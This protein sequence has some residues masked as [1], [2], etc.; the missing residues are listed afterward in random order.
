MGMAASSLRFA[1]LTARKNQVEFE[2][3]QINQQRLTLSQKSTALFNDML[4]KQVPTAPDPSAFTR[5]VYKFN[6]GFGESSILNLA[7]KA[8][9]AYNY[10]V[11]YKR[12]KTTKTLSRSSF[13][14]VGFT[15]TLGVTTSDKTKASYYARTA[16]VNGVSR[17]L[18]LVGGDSAAAK[19]QTYRDKL[20]TYNNMK[21]IEEQIRS[22]NNKNGSDVCESS[23]QQNIKSA[24]GLTT[25]N[26]NGIAQKLFGN[27]GKSGLCVTGVFPDVLA[28]NTSGINDE[29][30]KAAEAMVKVL[31]GTAANLDTNIT[32]QNLSNA[33]NAL[34]SL[35][36]SSEQL[37][38]T[39][40]KDKLFTDNTLKN[41]YDFTSAGA[42]NPDSKDLSSFQNL[43]E[44]E[45]KELINLLTAYAN[46]D[47]GTI[48]S[49]D[50]KYQV[51][52]TNY[53][54]YTNYENYGQAANSLYNLATGQAADNT[55]TNDQMVEM[56]NELLKEVGEGS[57]SSGDYKTKK[58]DPAF[59]Q[60]Q[61]ATATA[62]IVNIAAGQI[63]YEYQDDDGQKCYMYVSNE[64]VLDDTSSTYAE[65][66]SVYEN[67]L[68]Y[69]EGEMETESQDANVI[70]SDEGQ[71]SKITFAD[72]TVVTPEVVTEMD[73]DAYN[74]AMVEYEYKKDVYD[75][76]MN[77]C[78]AKVKIIQAQDQK[79]EVRLKQLDTEQKALST[80]IEALKSI[81]DKAI[82]SSFKTFS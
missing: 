52:D 48:S 63:L 30:A 27:T 21:T 56:L 79:L 75:K 9:G 76:E 61:S 55:V 58:V 41:E 82:E 31:N 28:L 38:S 5:I 14:N 26:R 70:M 7:R 45:K 69:L 80:E 29:K 54:N 4:T 2:G 37:M 11:T 39:H 73:N 64:N 18:T 57:S 17:N 42:S 74:Q 10:N 22:L 78:N 65:Q 8:S 13:S 43:N 19:L 3:Q 32:A 72:G 6:S 1:Q 77:D 53:T 12:P 35:T 60:Y 36:V 25:D 68:N 51:S 40:L 44:L 67:V 24:L 16:N 23:T 46:A 47:A 59:A 49:Y 33:V 34:G 66:V 15:T 20:E 81:R 71:V 62:G 50:A